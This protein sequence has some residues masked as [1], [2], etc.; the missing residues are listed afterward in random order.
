[1]VVG[2]RLVGVPGGG[3]RGGGGGMGGLWAVSFLYCFF[4]SSCCFSPLPP[5]KLGQYGGVIVVTH[6]SCFFSPGDICFL[7]SYLAF[8]PHLP[9]FGP[10]LFLLMWLPGSAVPLP[11]IEKKVQSTGQRSLE[12]NV[13]MDFLF[14]LLCVTAARPK[15]AF[16]E[17]SAVQCGM[18]S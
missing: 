4:F 9:S 13:L 15:Q 12:N 17:H 6:R 8:V 7:C 16:Q 10:P 2:A 5:P 1:M 14:G 11:K 18:R 3:G